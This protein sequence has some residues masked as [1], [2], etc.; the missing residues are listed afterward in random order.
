MDI[1]SITDLQQLKAMAYDQLVTK[2]TAEHNLQLITQR[3]AQL[4]SEQVEQP[5]AKAVKK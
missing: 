2:E 5:A 1:T 4:T 3:I